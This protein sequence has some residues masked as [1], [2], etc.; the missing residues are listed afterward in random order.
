MLRL[1]VWIQYCTNIT[2][3][4]SEA[5]LVW[6]HPISVHHHQKWCK[7]AFLDQVISQLII[8]SW[9]KSYHESNCNSLTDKLIEEI[10]SCKWEKNRQ[11]D[12]V[13]HGDPN[14]VDDSCTFEMDNVFITA[15]KVFVLCHGC[16]LGV[17]WIS[18]KLWIKFLF[19]PRN[20]ESHCYRNVWQQGID[21]HSLND[22]F[23][24]IVVPVNTVVIISTIDVFCSPIRL[25]L[26]H[27]SI[28]NKKQKTRIE[29]L[30]SK[31]VIGNRGK[32]LGERVLSNPVN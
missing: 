18:T 29:E 12:A 3:T 26:R 9:W 15:V 23:T 24:N 28:N 7:L 14:N 17:I 21:Q 4:I 32:L 2:I 5:F 16:L 8:K 31:Y 6:K 27:I 1:H 19:Q 22:N 30:S 11:T 13:E 20:S 10:E 25:V